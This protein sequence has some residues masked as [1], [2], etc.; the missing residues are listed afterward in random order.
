MGRVRRRVE[1]L[2]TALVLLGVLLVGCGDSKRN[3]QGI[4]FAAIGWFSDSAG[5]TG[6][7]GFDIQ[8]SDFVRG[9]TTPATDGTGELITAFLQVQ[10]FLAA[11][12]IRVQRVH[13]EYIVPGASISVPQTSVG[14]NAILGPVPGNFGDSPVNPDSTLPES[15]QDFSAVTTG[16]VPVVT[17]AVQQFIRLNLAQFPEP[18]FVMTVRSYA[19]AVTSARDRVDTNTVDLDIVFTPDVT[20]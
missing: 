18:P 1:V 4:S 7:S 11:Q 9:S 13:H 10:N 5:S 8:L 20:F 16:E 3:D 17:T 15:A 6:L 19:T 14:L 2:L 12:T